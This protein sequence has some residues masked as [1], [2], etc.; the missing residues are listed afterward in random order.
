MVSRRLLRRLA[1]D[2]AS[3]FWYI[4]SMEYIQSIILGVI[5][6]ITE[7]LPISSTGHLILS[8]KLL[9]IQESEFIKS[10]IIIIQLGA[11]LSVLLLYWRK[12]LVEMEVLKRVVIASI[13]TG[14]IGFIA[15]SFVKQYML[16]NAN[17]VAW[18]LIIGG[19][20]I[21]IFEK[22]YKGIN[23]SI[24]ELKDIPLK[25]AF[26]LGIAQ[27]LCVI[28]GVSRSAS[29][30]ISGR[31]L[32]LSKKVIVEFSFLLAVPVM[33]FATL[34]DI[35]KT[36]FSD[37]EWGILA[38]GF[39]VSFISAILGIKLLLNYIKEKP[40]T[41]FGVYRIILGLIFLLFVI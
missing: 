8:Y 3:F 32:N 38:M 29:T 4:K 7:F 9:N 18:S 16:G 20:L 15:Y 40:F 10:F 35:S 6:G 24:T 1:L 2:C 5:E 17:I 23:G 39:L 21:I 26:I 11:I 33:F 25:H 13:P 27:S 37:S 34:L 14:I 41:V 36:S 19:I 22:K 12:F 30:I 31:L 28:P